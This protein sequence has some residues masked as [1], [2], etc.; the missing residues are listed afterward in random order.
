MTRRKMNAPRLQPAVQVVVCSDVFWREPRSGGS[1]DIEIGVG[2]RPS[3]WPP[4][5]ILGLQAAWPWQLQD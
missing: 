1:D 5:E 2:A 3:S 4:V